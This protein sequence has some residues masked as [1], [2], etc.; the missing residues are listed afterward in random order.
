M[1]DQITVFR[2][3]L[4]SPSDV[5]AERQFAQEVIQQ[6]NDATAETLGATILPKVWERQPP[7]TPFLP[8]EK[9]QDQINREVERAHFFILILYK[10]YGNVEEGHTKSNTERELDTILRR[11]A[12]SPQIKILAYF[13]DLP[14]NSDPGD[15]EEQVRAF[16]GRLESQGV[17]YRTYRDPVHF[18][19]LV[20]HDLYSVVIRLRLGSFKRTALRRFW[21]IGESNREVYPRAA[22]I[23]PAVIRRFLG[24]IDSELWLN[25]LEP[26]V[27]YEDLRAVH[28]IQKTL[29]VVG[30]H[31]HKTFTTTNL[32]ADLH[33]M[34][35]IWVCF[36][37][38][39][40]ALKRLS[41][42]RGRARFQFEYRQDVARTARWNDA[43][44]TT[45]EIQSPL[46]T[47]LRLQRQGM[48]LSGECTAQ[49]RTITGR[50]FAVIS[51]FKNHESK[52]VCEDDLLYDYFIAGIRGLGTWGACWFID[53]RPRSFFALPDEGDLQ[54]LLEVHYENGAVVDAIDVSGQPPEYFQEQNDTGF[55]ANQIRLFAER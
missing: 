11:F 43:S 42:Y 2:A 10:R 45:F 8:E 21:R 37:R 1:A 6:I 19:E 39:Q 48:N 44:G 16:R 31:G 30:L 23:F 25:R 20:T 12:Q 18:R 9:I 54:I 5:A 46:A 51:R 28:K 17:R 4:S 36:P 47:Y 24:P 7:V 15:Q 52:D 32:P 14:P 55:I 27:Y 40:T 26:N 22:I 34:N 49:L 50:D 3:F 29:S 38:S 13:R 33:Y 35:T 53:R 41:R